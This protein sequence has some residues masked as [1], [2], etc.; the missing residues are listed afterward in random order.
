MPK[1]FFLIF[2]L[3]LCCV[4]SGFSF[5]V[6]MTEAVY[7]RRVAGEGVF[8]FD[9]SLAELKGAPK[10]SIE[11]VKKLIYSG[12][13]IQEYIAYK[14]KLFIGTGGGA[15][16]FSKAGGYTS[17]YSETTDILFLSGAYILVKYTEEFYR[18]PAAHGMTQTLYYIID[19][20]EKRLLGIDDIIETVP[21]AALQK[22]VG[23]KYNLDLSYRRTLWPPDTISFSTKG[24]VLFWNVYSIAP[25]VFGP[26]EIVLPFSV[27][28]PYLTA[29]GQ[30]LQKAFGIR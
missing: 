23:Q 9:F 21:E 14:E 15:N 18:A 26:T 22:A 5:D 19:T 12:K 24:L 8:Q 30:S 29:K 13:T 28:E 16:G 11:L 4:P 20:V 27:V 3:C 25:Y 2:A 7:E 6:K 1:R 10:A 17:N